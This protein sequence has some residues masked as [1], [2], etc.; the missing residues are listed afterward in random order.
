MLYTLP[1]ISYFQVITTSTDDLTLIIAQTPVREGS[2]VPVVIAGGY[3]LEIGHR[4]GYSM[5]V[6]W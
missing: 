6:T 3:D 4:S 2:S 1:Q 5:V